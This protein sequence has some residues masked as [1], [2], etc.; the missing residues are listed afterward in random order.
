MRIDPKGRVTA[1]ALDDGTILTETGAL[2]EYIAG[3]AP[4]AERIAENPV[5]AAHH[6]R[7]AMFYLASTMHV[8]GRGMRGARWAT[9][10]SSFEGMTALVPQTMAASAGFVEGAV[11]GAIRSGDSL[12]LPIPYLFIV[13]WLEGDKM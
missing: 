11:C 12:T 3:G 6:M 7:S 9:Q 13:S 2:L 1:L 4:E 8:P 5:E 10:Q